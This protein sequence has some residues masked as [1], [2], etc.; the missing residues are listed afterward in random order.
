M[1][2]RKIWSKSTMKLVRLFLHFACAGLVGT[3]GHYVVLI[4]LVRFVGVD[5]VVSSAF[6]A[7]TGASINYYLSYF[8]IFQSDKGHRETLGKFFTVAAYGLVLNTILMEILVDQIGI[9]YLVS[10]VMTSLVVL[11]SNFAGNFLW[12]FKT[13]PIGRTPKN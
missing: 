10:Q 1:L 9:N 5:P 2:S 12:T 6:G 11:G 13:R 4:V 3:F 8:Y 7:I